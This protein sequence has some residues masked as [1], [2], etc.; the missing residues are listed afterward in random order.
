MESQE[1]VGE[2]RKTVT[3]NAPIEKVW[4]AVSTSEGIAA[5]W[6]PNTLEP[7][8]GHEF[9]LHT[10]QYGDSP[11]KIT[12]VNPP[13]HIAFDWGKDWHLSIELNKLGDE[14]TELTLVHSGWNADQVT[15]FGQPHTV[16]RGFM[17]SG[18]E[19]IVKEKL[20]EIIEA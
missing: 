9:V 15:E 1:I 14:A 3:L 17:E 6:M 10:G 18:W 16:I 2:I 5:W 7:I 20:P 8:V 4:T 12:E 13:T 19:S 11:C